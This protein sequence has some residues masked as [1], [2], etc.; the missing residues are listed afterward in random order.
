MPGSAFSAR[1]THRALP[2]FRAFR[3]CLE[4]ATS[5]CLPIS[6]NAP[7]FG[8]LLFFLVSIQ[9]HIIRRFSKKSTKFTEK[10]LLFFQG[11]S[12]KSLPTQFFII[13]SFQ[14]FRKG[15]SQKKSVPSSRH[16]P[17]ITAPTDR[18]TPQLLQMPFC[19]NPQPPGGCFL[20]PRCARYHPTL[21]SPWHLGNP[22]RRCRHSHFAPV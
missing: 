20:R 2:L 12:L 14:Y 16:A 1:K 19:R 11:F 9:K 7:H 8:I 3:S 10:F 17:N 18:E 21:P 22:P 6:G 5:R 15:F 13:P 4:P